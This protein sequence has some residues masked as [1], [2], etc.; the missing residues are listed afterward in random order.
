MADIFSYIYPNRFGSLHQFFGVRAAASNLC[1][2]HNKTEYT[3]EMF[4][5]DFPQFGKLVK[6]YAS[7]TFTRDPSNVGGPNVVVEFDGFTATVSGLIAWYPEDTSVGR[8][9]GNRV[10]FEVIA[11]VDLEDVSNALCAIGGG[12]PFLLADDPNVSGNPRVF[13]WYPLVREDTTEH[14]LQLDWDGFG[15]RGVE[16]FTIKYENFTLEPAE[17]STPFPAKAAMFRALAEPGDQVVSLVPDAILDM[18]ILM[19]NAAIQ[20]CRWHEKWRYA[21]GLYIAHYATLYLRSYAEP[22]ENSNA[23]GAAGSGGLIGVVKSAHLGD[24]SVSYDVSSVV[25][26]TENWGAWNATAYGQLLVTEA[27]LVALGGSYII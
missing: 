10:G 8:P 1:F 14:T 5:A 3:K 19:A 13:W 22:T 20:E 26:A 18:F 4:L 6:Q 16:T 9:A 2:C 11:P 12:T 21:M 17:D 7:S 15:Q 27:R 25:S 23:S 24:T